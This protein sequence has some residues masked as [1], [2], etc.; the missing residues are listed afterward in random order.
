METNLNIVK[1]RLS[2]EKNYKKLTFVKE[3]KKKIL[4]TYYIISFI[5]EKTIKNKLVNF[6]KIKT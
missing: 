3:N 2:E 1:K 6:S 5:L 4:D